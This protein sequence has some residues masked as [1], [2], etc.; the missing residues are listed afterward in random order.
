MR[1]PVRALA[2]L[3]PV[4]L[5]AAACA[6]AGAPATAPSEGGRTAF[7]GAG[8][9]ATQYS[10]VDGKGAPGAIPAPEFTT[11]TTA[12]TSAT[13][14]LILT[15]SVSMKSQDPWASADKARAIATGLGGDVLAMSQTGQGENR[16]ALLT[17]RVPSDRFDEAL[18]QLKLLDGEVVN[19]S[20]DAK[21]VT[22]QFTDLQARLVAKQAE[23]QRYLQLFPQA[24]TVDETLKIDAALGNVRMQIEQLQGQINLIKTRTEY[25]TISMSIAPLVT[26]P[27]ET[28]GAWDPAKT[29]AKAIA[30]LSVFF[31]FAADLAIWLLVF[32]WIPLIGL[33]IALAATRARRPT[34]TTT[35]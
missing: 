3:V 30:A 24:K 9:A 27:A 26:V 17:V 32:G 10:A 11:N 7:G 15:A 14:N 2:L 13:R 29:F 4:V 28:G 25:S 19:S 31:K 5:L 20:V 22:D 33:A 16:S 23:E 34:V 18:R 12:V 1:R 35:P 21:D 6:T 8:D